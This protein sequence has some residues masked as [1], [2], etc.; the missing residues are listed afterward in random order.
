MAYIIYP[1]N[2]VAVVAASE[3]SNHFKD[4][5][6]CVAPLPVNTGYAMY[7]DD[8]GALKN[9]QRNQLVETRLGYGPIFGSAFVVSHGEAG[10]EHSD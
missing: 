10:E 4:D 2:R 5:G 1:D 3:L 9:L 6:F 7:V 8:C